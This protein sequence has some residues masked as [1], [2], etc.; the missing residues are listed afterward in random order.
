MKLRYITCSDPREHNSIESMFK[1]ARMPHAEI[2]VQC[3][4]SK[5]NE[6]MPRNIWFRELLRESL[7]LSKPINLAIHINSEWANDICVNGHIPVILS[8][9][10][11]L[12]RKN[13]PLIKRI[14]IN[15]PEQTANNFNP[16]YMAAIISWEFP[17]QEFIF[18]YNNKTKNAIEKLHRVQVPFSLLFDASGGRGI[19]PNQW[20]KPIYEN[21]PMGYSGGISPDN[22]IRN[23][24]EISKQNPDNSEIWIDAEG[25][26]KDQ[27]YDLFGEKPQFNVDLARA[28]IN[29]A[30]IWQK[31]NINQK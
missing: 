19:A 3:H 25:K 23:L 22:V 10:M 30:N 6:G 28:Y 26:L 13:K 24:N 7:N 31:K 16:D 27:T 18:Q 5:M 4:P 14:Q 21:H 20:Q 12:K 1:L 2:A 17:D 11:C 29:R 15:M 9:W 8:E